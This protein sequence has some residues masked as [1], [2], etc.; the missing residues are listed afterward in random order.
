VD[1]AYQNPDIVGS[2]DEKIS[3]PSNENILS[4]LPTPH[5]LFSS[6]SPQ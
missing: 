4:P 5:S 6:Q 2:P 3:P 1:I